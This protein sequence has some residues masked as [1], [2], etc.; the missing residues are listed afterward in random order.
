[1]AGACHRHHGADGCDGEHTIRDTEAEDG[2]A[3]RPLWTH[4]AAHRDC[5]H[6][7]TR[8]EATPNHETAQ[9]MGFAALQNLRDN[10]DANHAQKNTAMLHSTELR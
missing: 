1:M 5:C 8:G 9:H 4:H 10:R 3:D 6:E 7:Q 2:A